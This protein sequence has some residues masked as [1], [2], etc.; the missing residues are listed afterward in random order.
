MPKI[1]R[2]EK[3]TGCGTNFEPLKVHDAA[4]ML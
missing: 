1:H 4:K 2:I 3:C